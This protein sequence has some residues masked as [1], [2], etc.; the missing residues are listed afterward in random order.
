MEVSFSKKTIF[1]F[2]VLIWIVFSVFYIVWDIWTNFKQV[3]IMA[4]YEQGRID[5]INVLI[6]ETEKCESVSVKGTEK[7]TKVIS[8]HCLTE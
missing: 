3:Q 5:T 7:E 4:A 2:F 6:S 1:S 8:V